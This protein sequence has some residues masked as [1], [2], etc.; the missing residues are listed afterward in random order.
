MYFDVVNIPRCL[1]E[2]L[3]CIGVGVFCDNKSLLEYI[4][5]K[6]DK[7]VRIYNL[8]TTDLNLS[9]KILKKEIREK[10]DIVD[11]INSADYIT[12]N[13]RDWN[14]V[15]EPTKF[16]LPK[17]FKIFHEIIVDGISINTIYKKR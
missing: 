6:D 2:Q 11:N 17:N 7:K 15:Y 1:P 4:I 3:L 10:I 16:M 14:G 12:N 9:K 8:S 5:E 13:Y